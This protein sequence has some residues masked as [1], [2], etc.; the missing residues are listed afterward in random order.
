MYSLIHV[1]YIAS[2]HLLQYKTKNINVFSLTTREKAFITFISFQHHHH[3]HDLII[4]VVD[5]ASRRKPVNVKYI[6]DL[7][8]FWGGKGFSLKASLLL[9]CYVGVFRYKAII[10]YHLITY[11][12]NRTTH[13][14]PFTFYK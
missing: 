9:M 3:N 8:F 1:R 4:I 14:P 5:L 7:C 13:Y 12:T 6:L 2:P 10:S 11:P